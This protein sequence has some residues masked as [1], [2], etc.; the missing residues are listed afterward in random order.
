M[1]RMSFILTA[2]VCL[3][4]LGLTGCASG[5]SDDEADAAEEESIGEVA[6]ALPPELDPTCYAIDACFS[7]ANVCGWSHYTQLVMGTYYADNC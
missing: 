3:H 2:F 6:S 4:F 5:V 1:K 7:S